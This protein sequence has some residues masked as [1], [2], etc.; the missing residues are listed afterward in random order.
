MLRIDMSNLQ[1]F[2]S[3][4]SA[5]PGQIECVVYEAASTELNISTKN[6]YIFVFPSALVN[7]KCY[8][9]YLIYV[10]NFISLCQFCSVHHMIHCVNIP[11]WKKYT[12][13]I[14]LFNDYFYISTLFCTNPLRTDLV[15]PVKQN[16]SAHTT[17]ELCV[18]LLTV[19]LTALF[20]RHTL[21][22]CILFSLHLYIYI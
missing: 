2:T 10:I 3:F 16:S 17:V 8:D 11:L 15:L 7:T 1:R 21:F 12:G 20:I 4:T 14:F 13:K 9:N 18:L 19:G 6:I 22:T 5:S